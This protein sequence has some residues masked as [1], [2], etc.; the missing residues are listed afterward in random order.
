MDTYL[1]FSEEDRHKLVASQRLLGPGAE[2][3]VGFV[4]EKHGIPHAAEL[5]RPLERLLHVRGL[6]AEVAG[7]HHVEGD[8]GPLGD[9]LRGERLAD[10]GGAEHEDDQAAALVGDEVVEPV[11]G[12]ALV[13]D[14]GP[15]EVLLAAGQHELVEG[16]VVPGHVAELVDAQLA[17]ALGLHV[18]SLDPG[19]RQKQV[20][21]AERSEILAPLGR[22]LG[23]GVD[24]DLDGVELRLVGGFRNLGVV[25][26][27]TWLLVILFVK[28]SQLGLDDV[29][30]PIVGISVDTNPA[31]HLLCNSV[32]NMR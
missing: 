24:L 11:L 29:A 23:S 21:F 6:G 9:S 18:E 22:S 30:A 14:E 15:R 19:N 8:A 7:A 27:A 2:E 20:F 13:L 4:E 3:D 1:Q 28:R 12:Q 17:P 16:R 26:S 31:R 10:A 32:R 25:G 5:E